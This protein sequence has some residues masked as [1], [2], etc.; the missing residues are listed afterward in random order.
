MILD[1]T[2]KCNYTSPDSDVIKFAYHFLVEEKKKARYK[3]KMKTGIQKSQE[4]K[5]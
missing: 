4:V 1:I 5:R 3:I 2:E